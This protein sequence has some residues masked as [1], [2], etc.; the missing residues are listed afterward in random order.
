[1]QLYL[2]TI[3]EQSRGYTCINYAYILCIH[4][5]YN[6][7]VDNKKIAQDKAI[8]DEFR[9]FHVKIFRNY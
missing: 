9:G 4:Y 6:L 7:H 1:M 5:K 8:E 3:G 2:S